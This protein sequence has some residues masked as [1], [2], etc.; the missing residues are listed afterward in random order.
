MG[1]G[2]AAKLL[3]VSVSTVR[4]WCDSGHLPHWRTPTGQRRFNEQELR[5]WLAK[6]QEDKHGL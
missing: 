3:G 1:I 6:R 5:E 2:E 4:L